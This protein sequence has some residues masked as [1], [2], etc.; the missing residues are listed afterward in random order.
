MSSG[1]CKKCDARRPYKSSKAEYVVVEW[2]EALSECM[3]CSI[4]WGQ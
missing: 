4:S 1:G 2:V 3:R